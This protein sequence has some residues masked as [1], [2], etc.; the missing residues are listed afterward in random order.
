MLEIKGDAFLAAI[1]PDKVRRES[2]RALVVGA[3][4]VADSGAFDFDYA[5]AVVGQM[6]GRE[7]RGD[8]VLQG[9][10]YNAV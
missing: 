9:E 10:D 2:A 5:R 1:G 4:K 6:S 7:R 8:S 3:R